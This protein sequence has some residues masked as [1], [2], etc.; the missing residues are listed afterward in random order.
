MAVICEMHVMG[1]STGPSTKWYSVNSAP[2]DHH[3]LFNMTTT[4][5]FVDEES[6]NWEGEVTRSKSQRHLTIES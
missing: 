4:L 6:K 2:Q 1:L 3:F 5:L